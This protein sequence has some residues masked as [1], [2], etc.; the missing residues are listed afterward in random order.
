MC[1][2]ALKWSETDEGLF[3]LKKC[4]ISVLFCMSPPNVMAFFPPNFSYYLCCFCVWMSE[5]WI[6]RKIS[7]HNLHFV[8]CRPSEVKDGFSTGFI[9][10]K[11]SVN[12]KMHLK[13]L[14][15]N[16]WS[17]WCPV[18]IISKVCKQ[19]TSCDN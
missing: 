11:V 16:L 10:I 18:C 15:N 12:L 9:C 4:P 19:S 7:F 14:Y 2:R 17:C 8:A 1:F 13:T 3:R 5:T 6:G